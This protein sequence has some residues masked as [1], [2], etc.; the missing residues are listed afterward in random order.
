[1]KKKLLR[2]ISMLL[3]LALLTA[4][5]PGAFAA[6][7]ETAAESAATEQLRGS[8]QNGVFMDSQVLSPCEAAPATRGIGNVNDV[9]FN[10]NALEQGCVI[11]RTMKIE[12]VLHCE[13]NADNP[14]VGFALYHGSSYDDDNSNITE[15]NLIASGTDDV[16]VNPGPGDWNMYVSFDTSR[17]S[18]GDYT[19]TLDTQ[20]RNGN[21]DADSYWKVTIHLFEQEVPLE[22]LYFFDTVQEMYIGKD[23]VIPV[24]DTTTF[25]VVFFPDCTTID[26]HTDVYSQDNSIVTAYNRGGYINVTGISNGTADIILKIGDLE[27]RQKVIVGTGSPVNDGICHGGVNCPSLKFYDIC[28]DDWYHPY[29]DYVVS[30]HLMGGTSDYTFEPESPMTRAMLVTV[31]WRFEGEPHEGSN[32]FTDVPGGQWFTDAIAWAALNHIVGGVGNGHFEP[33]GNITRE[34]MAAILFRYAQGKGIDTS[35]RTDLTGFP[36]AGK[37]SSWAQDA[38]QWAVATKLI[39]GSSGLLIPDGNATRAQV[40]TILQR[41]ITTV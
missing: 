6:E 18:A 41:F 39:G 38:M 16:S 21:I 34:Q 28:S 15:A 13:E 20:D 5:L 10:D 11:G 8:A 30:H 26:R 2:M 33:E 37:V 3:C 17:L 25:C 36:D 31:L 40:A 22:N 19:L 24:N 35:A 9:W 4:V 27:F 7:E 23:L 29:V 14:I 32:I 12:Y 1:M